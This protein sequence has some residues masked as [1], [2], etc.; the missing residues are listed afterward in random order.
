MHTSEF[1]SPAY[2][3]RRVPIADLVSQKA[4]PNSMTGKSFD[5]LQQSILNT[6]YTFPIIAALND[7]YDSATEA[8]DRPSLIEMSD[9]EQTFTDSGKIGTQVSDDEVAKYFP[10]R[11]IDGSHRTQVVR[12]GTHYFYKSFE[13]KAE[14]WSKGEEIPAVPGPAMLAYIAWRENF[15]IPAV[16]LEIDS[17]KQMSAEILHN[18]A[19]GSHSLDGMKDI[20][21]NLINIAGMSEEWV[22]RNLYLDLE[23]IKRM[24]QLSGLKAAMEDIDDADM[25]WTPEKDDSYQRKMTAYLIREASKFIQIYKQENPDESFDDTGSALDV[26]IRLGFD[27]VEATKRHVDAYKNI[28]KEKVDA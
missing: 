3:V 2:G 1:S 14:P 5:A 12:L 6:G 11:L 20:V 13:N 28:N 7:E 15:S 23:S 16:I 26:A 4:N 21:Y 8:M 18:T 27:Q 22:S 24:Q 9:G 19:R 10:Y 17:T 25:A